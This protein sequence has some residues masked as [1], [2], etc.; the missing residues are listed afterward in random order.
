M[1][2]CTWLEGKNRVEKKISYLRLLSRSD[3]VVF[4]QL[5]TPGFDGKRSIYSKVE[6]AAGNL[7]IS[8]I[9]YFVNRPVSLQ[10]VDL[11]VDVNNCGDF[12]V[13][14]AIRNNVY[15]GHKMVG[16]NLIRT[17]APE[18]EFLDSI[19][20]EDDAVWDDMQRC[21]N[22]VDK[23]SPSYGELLPNVV[24]SL[25]RSLNGDAH[26]IHSIL[27]MDRFLTYIIQEKKTIKTF[28]N[29][30]LNFYAKLIPLK[31]MW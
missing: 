17:R 10:I 11:G 24:N 6:N 1:H 5:H 4:G 30:H 18:V 15:Y 9:G 28:E 29:D 31:Q 14:D 25:E 3:S 8:G 20:T 19:S 2:S 13:L 27:R 26:T 12:C 16:V 22:D 7:C 23:S 21:M